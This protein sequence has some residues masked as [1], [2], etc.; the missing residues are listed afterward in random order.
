MNNTDEQKF[1]E[2]SEYMNQLDE[3]HKKILQSIEESKKAIHKPDK[4]DKI[5]VV[6]WA[7]LL[8]I[9]IVFIFYN[10]INF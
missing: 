2:L 1:K 5:L 4:P 3:A 8:I 7:M 9:F 6:L 10:I